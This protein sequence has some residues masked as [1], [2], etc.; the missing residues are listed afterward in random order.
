MAEPAVAIPPT[1]ESLPADDIIVLR[2]ATWADYQRLLAIRGESSVPRITYLEGVLE[3]MSPSFPHESIK[4]MIGRLVEVWCL[5]RGVDISAYGSWTH[6]SKKAKRGV[7]PDECYVLGEDTKPTRCDLA[8]EV[9]WTRGA[10]KKIEV[11]RKLGVRELW[12]WKAGAITV[13]SLEGEQYVRVKRSK[14]LPALDLEELLT[15][16][17]VKPMTRAM[18]EYREKLRTGSA[19]EP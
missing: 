17:D 4:S 11:Y 12:I 2:G 5:E 19:H 1:N 15:F 10:I 13:H 6:Q 3:L 14:L 8:I 7:E 18:R 16:V 9:E